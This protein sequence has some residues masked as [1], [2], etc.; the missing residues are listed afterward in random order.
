MTVDM[1]LIWFVLAGFI[2]GFSVSTLWEWL[3]FRRRRVAAVGMAVPTVGAV[4]GSHA[5]A[6]NW[7][8]GDEAG[9]SG[10]RV[11]VGDIEDTEEWQPDY[12]SPAVFTEFEDS[13]STQEAADAPR[14]S[15]GANWQAL[16]APSTRGGGSTGRSGVAAEET[17][18]SAPPPK[19]DE[20]V[21]EDRR[22]RTGATASTRPGVSRASRPAMPER[23]RNIPNAASVAGNEAPKSEPAARSSG[24]T[25]SATGDTG[26]SPVG[27]G[28]RQGPE[29]ATFR[30][31][32]ARAAEDPPQTTASG[33]GK[34]VSEVP[35]PAATKRAPNKTDNYPDDLLK[36]KGIGDVYKRR[37][38][39]AGICTWHQIAEA[40]EDTLRAA[41]SAYPSS[42]VDEWSEQARALA[43][44]HGRTGA[45]YSGPPPQDLT[46]I[47]GIGRVGEATLFRAGI[48]TYAQLAA[49]TPADL[50]P[51]FPIAVAGDE[52]DFEHWIAQ[53]RDYSQE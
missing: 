34:A 47:Y 31:P 2:L 48:C 7:E 26:G 27:T 41:T 44:K 30:R 9:T 36:I 52:P 6:Q 8:R 10:P 1:R 39:A 35:K 11:E 32:P 33:S 14:A 21:P 5:S 20:R 53:A 25:S 49:A 3:Y 50:A 51:L 42:N 4:E 38:Y 46:R 15:Q 18:A 28:E 29:L 40:E 22:G 12:V 19:E 37:L 23:F 43:Q 13:E 45:V 16:V 17:G 24:G